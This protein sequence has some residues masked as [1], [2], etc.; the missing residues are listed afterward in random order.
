MA[1]GDW[2]R[3]GKRRSSIPAPAGWTVYLPAPRPIHMALLDICQFYEELT[4]GTPV[5]SVAG[6]VVA[7]YH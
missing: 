5:Y 6:Q 7:Y 4:G 2:R 1:A 3:L